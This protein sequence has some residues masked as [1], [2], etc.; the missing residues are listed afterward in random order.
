MTKTV[1]ITCAAHRIGRAVALGLAEDG[2]KIAIHYSN[3]ANAANELAQIITDKG[4]NA[5][6]LQANLGDAGEANNLISRVVETVG[7]LSALINNASVFERDE[8]TT[9][10]DD[11]WDMHLNV[12]LKAPAI[13]MRDF[14]TQAQA[15]GNII[16]I[17]DQR[18]WRLNPDFISYTVSKTGL[19][20]L[21]QTFAQ[22]LAEQQ[23]RVNGIGPGPT[24]ANQ[25]Q[26]PEEFEKQ[27]RLVP[28]GSGANPQDIIDGVRYILSAQ[29]MTGQM[30]ALDGGQHLAWK[31]PDVTEVVE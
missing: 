28:L 16:N 12:N 9:L 4:G 13:L 3:S 29:A 23:I 1:L 24:L 14:A 15:G 17:I 30:I 27:T 10:T 26:N 22:A 6:T 31:T 18:V 8:V 25:R 20:T 2:W 7:P 5:E 21:T 11:S 19:W